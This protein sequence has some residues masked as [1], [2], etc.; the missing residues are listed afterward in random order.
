LT[1]ATP[2]F[3]QS[4]APF[5]N[6]ASAWT[7]F[8]ATDVTRLQNS[9]AWKCCVLAM[10]YYRN[11]EYTNALTWADNTISQ[12]AP[13]PTLAPAAHAFRAMALYR[14]GQVQEAKLELDWAKEVVDPIFKK[15]V[16][17]VT[18]NEG[19]WFEWHIDRIYINEAE[20]MMGESAGASAR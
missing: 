2:A 16:S 10:V 9:K 3:M 14:I 7:N 18:N 20:K 11:G 12:H 15:G 1:P 17:K 5:V 13:D 4:L 19:R 8:D 6:V